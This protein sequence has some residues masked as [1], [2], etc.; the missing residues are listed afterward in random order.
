MPQ[1]FTVTEILKKVMQTIENIGYPTKSNLYIYP[2]T[3]MLVDL[4]L[5]VFEVKYVTMILISMHQKPKSNN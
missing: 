2:H 3:R 1:L 5:S 4:L